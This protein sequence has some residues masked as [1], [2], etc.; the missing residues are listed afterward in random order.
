M[1][2]NEI[3]VIF[4]IA[5]IIIAAMLIRNLGPKYETQSY[6]TQ[7]G[8]EPTKSIQ[9]DRSS[10]KAKVVVGGMEFEVD[11]SGNVERSGK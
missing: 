3:I 8:E 4:I 10:G 7:A 5:A 9:I 1:S 2:K 11:K 6:D